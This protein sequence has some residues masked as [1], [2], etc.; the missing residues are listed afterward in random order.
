M[1]NYISVADAVVNFGF[2]WD[3]IAPT[4]EEFVA[5]LKKQPAADVAP[6]VHGHWIHLK[7]GEVRCS[8][9]DALTCVG[10]DLS[11]MTKDI[12]YCY[13]CGAKMNGDPPISGDIYEEYGGTYDH[14]NMDGS[15]L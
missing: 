4:R 1:D 15:V 6:V 3:D 8:V 9:C 11:E 5:F 13:N 2:E 14:G 10:S 7:N 12:F